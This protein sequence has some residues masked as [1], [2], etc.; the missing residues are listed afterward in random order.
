MSKTAGKIK[1][2]FGD[3]LFIDWYWVGKTKAWD[4]PGTEDKTGREFCYGLWN[5]VLI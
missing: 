5:D 4:I 2:E 1:S 3:R